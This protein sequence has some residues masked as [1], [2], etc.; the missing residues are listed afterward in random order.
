MT[1]THDLV[2]PIGITHHGLLRI[3]RDKF[4]ETVPA[5]QLTEDN[6]L[7]LYLLQQLPKRLQHEA[8]EVRH[9]I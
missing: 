6:P 4:L 2:W 7:Q 3:S 9:E 5:D 1:R 8:L